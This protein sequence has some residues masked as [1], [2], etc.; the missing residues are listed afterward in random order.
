F[1]RNSRDYKKT[2]VIARLLAENGYSVITGGGPGLMEAANKGAAEGGG[3]SIGLNITLPEEQKPNSFQNKSIQFKYFFARKVMFVK[4]AMGYVCMPGGFGTLDELFEALTLM[5]THKIYTFP[6]IL[7]GTEYWS[8]LIEWMKDVMC[9][10]RTVSKKDFDF[11]TLTDDPEE[12]VE[13]MNRHRRWRQ[14]KGYMVAT[15]MNGM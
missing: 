9:K 10:R 5:Q 14:K 2:A 11:I 7:C 6:L 4:Y 8:G 15:E 13:I 1:H 3:A 12:I